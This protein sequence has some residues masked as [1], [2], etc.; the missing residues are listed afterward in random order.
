MRG[1]LGHSFASNVYLNDPDA[2][3]KIGQMYEQ[4]LCIERDDERALQWYRK[5]AEK[6]HADAYFAMAEIFTRLAREN[7]TKAADLGHEGACAELGWDAAL[8]EEEQNYFNRALG[9]M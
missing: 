8:S 6:N 5:A 9:V 2:L 7:Y 1:N 3:Y 4:G